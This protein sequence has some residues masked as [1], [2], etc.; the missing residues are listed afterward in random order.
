M[1]MRLGVKPH[2]FLF[3]AVVVFLLTYLIWSPVAP[4]YTRL[5]SFL[6]EGFLHLTEGGSDPNLDDVSRLW[7]E[8]TTIYFGHR[9]FPTL[10]APG[11]PAEWVQANMVLLIPLMLA[12]PAATWAQRFSRLGLAMLLALVLQVLDLS[13]TVKSFFANELGD[14]SFR[15]FSDSARWWYNFGDAFAQSMDTQLFPF[16]IWAGIHFRQLVGG[17]LETPAE[18]APAGR[19]ERR[20]QERQTRKAKA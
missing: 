12:T 3:R 16:A 20:R 15:Y 7:V 10:R 8:N 5:L 18:P 1:P 4:A 6:T 2:V 9:L 19:S 11:I 14:Y 13:V 17:R